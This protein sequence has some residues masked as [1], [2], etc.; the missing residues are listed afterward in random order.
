M[1]VMLCQDDEKIVI[2]RNLF[3]FLNNNETKLEIDTEDIERISNE[4]CY[5]KISEVEVY[6]KE[7]KKIKKIKM[8]YKEVIE[9][10]DSRNDKRYEKEQTFLTLKE[11]HENEKNNCNSQD[12]K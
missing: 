5:N 12:N 6:D 2:Y 1:E 10:W 3:S 4:L 11:I 7:Y 9:G 8:Y